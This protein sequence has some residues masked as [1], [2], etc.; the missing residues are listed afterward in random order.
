VWVD[1]RL[2]AAR[3]AVVAAHEDLKTHPAAQA[4]GAYLEDK[5]YAVAVHTRR[6]ADPTAGLRRSTRQPARLPAATGWSS[7][8]SW[9]GSCAPPCAATRAAPSAGSPPWAV[10]D[11]GSRCA[12]QK[13]RQRC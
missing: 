5:E 11:C 4:S 12:R 13:H 7:Q 1:P 8:A 10:T 9:Y 2:G 6:I 3:S